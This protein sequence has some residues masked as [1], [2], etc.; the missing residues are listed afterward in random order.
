MTQ[1]KSISI[2][3]ESIFKRLDDITPVGMP[4]SEQV[5]IAVNS[6]VDNQDIDS[7]KESTRPDFLCSDIGEWKAY[8]LNHQ[9][10]VGELMRRHVQ[11]KNLLLKEEHVIR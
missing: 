1:V 2:K 3:D 4:F 6:Y 7:V 10:R 11:L 8:I 9:E 5:S